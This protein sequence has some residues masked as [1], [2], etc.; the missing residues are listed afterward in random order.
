MIT[1]LI[2]DCLLAKLTCTCDNLSSV[3]F[4]DRSLYKL[5]ALPPCGKENIPLINE[6]SLSVSSQPDSIESD[7][8]DE[9]SIDLGHSSKRNSPVDH[10]HQ[11]LGPHNHHLS[12][13]QATE[14][15]QQM[16]AAAATALRQQLG[17]AI[18]F[19]GTQNFLG[20]LSSQAGVQAAAN[21]TPNPN[22]NPNVA[23]TNPTPSNIQGGDILKQQQEQFLAALMATAS[24]QQQPQQQA[25]PNS[26]ANPDQQAA[27]RAALSMM[28]S[29]AMLIAASNAPDAMAVATA[30]QA[31]GVKGAF[32]IL[33]L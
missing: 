10:E 8:E 13:Q 27:A 29:N 16:A 23:S 31:I 19:A 17:A 4:H 30:A 9:G 14:Q 11:H 18:N 33:L 15:Q 5:S 2:H 6:T 21:S 12:Q 32:I 24:Q 20:Q 1:I 3:L 7:H 25:T 26:N 22:S 28:A